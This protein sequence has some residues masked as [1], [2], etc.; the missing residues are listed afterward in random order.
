MTSPDG[1]VIAQF[2]VREQRWLRTLEALRDYHQV[3]TGKLMT[4]IQWI[5]GRELGHLSWLGYYWHH[6]MF[7]FGYGLHEAVWR[8]LIEADNRSKY[9]GVLENL[10]AELSGTWE[11][12]SA[13]ENLYRRL[14]SKADV[15]GN[16]EAELEW[17]KARSRE[18]HEF[19]V[20]PAG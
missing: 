7:W 15:A 19:V 18:L 5:G 4:G 20:Q 8:P 12:I 1:E 3:Q 14:W 11:S 9:S 17:F 2:L 16:S 6:E 10:R 13:E